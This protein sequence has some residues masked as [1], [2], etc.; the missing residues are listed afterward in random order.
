VLDAVGAQPQPDEIARGQLGRQRAL[1]VLVEIAEA[2]ACDSGRGRAAE[3][4]R[5]EPK[6]R[7]LPQRQVEPGEDAEEARLAGAARAEHGEDLAL[8]DRERQA[9]QGGGVALGGRVD[10]EEVAGLDG[11]AHA[12]SP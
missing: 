2:P 6:T 4:R 3:R 7:T 8:R 9:L 11:E 10:A 12:V 5:S 1:V